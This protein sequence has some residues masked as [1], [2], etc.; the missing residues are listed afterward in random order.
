MKRGLFFILVLAALDIY[1]Y[2]G[3]ETITASLSPSIKTAIKITYIIFVILTLLSLLAYIWLRWGFRN[4]FIK[5][6]L[7][8][9]WFMKYI[10]KLFT[11][12]FLFIDDISRLAKWG[13]YKFAHLFNYN[14]ADSLVLSRSVSLTKI[15]MLAATVPIATLGYGILS[16]AHDYRIRRIRIKLPHLPASFHGLR[17]GQLSDIHSGSF[18]NK[19]AVAA[20]V[21]MLL[22]ERPDVI[23]FTGDLVNDTADEV[24]DYIS[25]FS[26]LKAPLGI[27]STLGNHDYGDYVPWP[28]A[29]AKQQNLKDLCKVHELLGWQLLMNEHKLLTHGTDKIAIIGIE[30]WG[31]HFAQYGKLAQ[32]Y[33]NLPEDISVKLLLSHDPSHWDAE[34]RPKFSDIDIMFAGHTHGFQFGIEIGSFKWSP[35]QYQYKQWAGLYQEDNQYLYVN[36]GFGY[37]GYPG[38]IGIL[39][40]ITIVELEKG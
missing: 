27:Y 24:K 5:Y 23:F 32:A 11:G 8:P 6:K 7:I 35:V 13:I 28:S 39:P 22:H 14:L 18:F 38:R 17:I 20:G 15:G 29:V 4:D 37:I 1:F 26:K 19:K 34:V 21:D 36:R 31:L 25:I 2:Q 30:N 10:V 9:T 40:E 16:G 33:Q 3:L 12:L